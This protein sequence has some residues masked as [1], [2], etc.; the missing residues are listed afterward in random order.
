M[1][2]LLQHGFISL[3]LLVSYFNFDIRPPISLRWNGKKSSNLSTM[4]SIQEEHVSKTSGTIWPIGGRY[5]YYLLLLKLS[6]ECRLY[7]VGWV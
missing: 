6:F 2:W 1:N 3:T 5:N 4:Y 7:R